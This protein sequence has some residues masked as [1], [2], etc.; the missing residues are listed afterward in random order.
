LK[1]DLVLNTVLLHKHSRQTRSTGKSGLRVVPH[2]IENKLL[3]LAMF[4]VYVFK[5]VKAIYLIYK[6]TNGVEFNYN[7]Q[8]KNE[9]EDF[10]DTQEIIDTKKG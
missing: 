2:N 6:L 3:A 7:T 4:P 5:G 9:P 8:N 10:I 1:P